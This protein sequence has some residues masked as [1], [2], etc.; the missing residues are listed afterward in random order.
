MKI[1]L[2]CDKNEV[3]AGHYFCPS[4]EIASATACRAV[5]GWV[6]HDRFGIDDNGELFHLDTAPLPLLNPGL[7]LVSIRAALGPSLWTLTE[8]NWRSRQW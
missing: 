3:R 2:C 5:T 8:T 7:A 6:N 1:C 4:C